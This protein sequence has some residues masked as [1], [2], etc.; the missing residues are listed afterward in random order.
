M[1]LCDYMEWL[2]VSLV[3]DKLIGFII[4]LPLGGLVLLCFVVSV[5]NGMNIS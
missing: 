3:V 4:V 1:T 2:S 5:V